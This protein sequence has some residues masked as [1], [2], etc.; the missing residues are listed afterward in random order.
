[1]TENDNIE[2]NRNKNNPYF[3]LFQVIAADVS[4]L[5][6]LPDKVQTVFV[7]IGFAIGFLFVL[8]ET[9][10]VTK[11]FCRNSNKC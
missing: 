2:E 11:M 3:F 9:I 8:P 7:L 4:F 1:M 6:G 5:V 10:F